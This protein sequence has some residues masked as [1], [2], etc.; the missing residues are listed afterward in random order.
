MRIL[1]GALLALVIAA[2]PAA[3]DDDWRALAQAT[4]ARLA[5]RP[6]D[7]DLLNLYGYYA[8]RSGV[9]AEAERAF[10]RAVAQRRA[11]PVAWN[12]L[13]ALYLNLDRYAEAERCFR[14]ALA[15]DPRYAKARYN[16]AVTRFKQGEYR[17]ALEMYLDLRK[18][19]SD[20]VKLRTDPA[21]AEE[22]LDEALKRDPT[23]PFLLTVKQ[24]YK[25]LREEK[26]VESSYSW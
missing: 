4:Y 10:Q 20:Y 24:R 14:A 21:K 8:Y 18:S 9:T 17:E 7:P 25:R 3:A 11:F 19:D 6:T 13:G 16:L 22:E 5:T 15:A 1:S 26:A 23:N 2:S 12:N